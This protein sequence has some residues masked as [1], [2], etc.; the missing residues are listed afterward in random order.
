MGMAWR[1]HPDLVG[2]GSGTKG[3]R[4]LPTVYSIAVVAESTRVHLPLK[5]SVYL[6]AFNLLDNDH[7]E[8][9]EGQDRSTLW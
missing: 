5:A 9:P 3:D 2:R 7:R 8:H 6:R 1:R 4:R